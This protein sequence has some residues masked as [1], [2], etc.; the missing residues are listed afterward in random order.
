MSITLFKNEKYN[1]EIIKRQ[2][3]RI[4]RLKGKYNSYISFN[5]N[6]L[7]SDDYYWFCD[8]VGKQIQ[9]TIDNV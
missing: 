5:V 7:S 9:E 4:F 6:Y 1:C 2:N 8:T 3:S